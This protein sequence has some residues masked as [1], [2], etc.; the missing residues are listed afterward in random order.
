MATDDFRIPAREERRQVVHRIEHL[1]GMGESHLEMGSV[2]M[3][4]SGGKTRQSKMVI[5]FTILF[6]L[7]PRR[8][9]RKRRQAWIGSGKRKKDQVGSHGDVVIGSDGKRKRERNVTFSRRSGSASQD[10]GRE[11]RGLTALASVLYGQARISGNFGWTGGR[12]KLKV[13]NRSALCGTF[14]GTWHID[15][16]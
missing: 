12:P 7:L 13:R 15:W 5:R 1:D 9:P 11:T 16:R 10:D 8:F 14:A 4:G 3:V 2:T 6:T